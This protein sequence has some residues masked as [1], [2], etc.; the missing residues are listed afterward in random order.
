VLI[1]DQWK[2]IGKQK[3]G[4]GFF[5]QIEEFPFFLQLIVNKRKQP[6]P[7]NRL[8]QDKGAKVL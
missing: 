8:A 1:Y 7:E 5:Y 6:K 2:G 3:Q 4:L